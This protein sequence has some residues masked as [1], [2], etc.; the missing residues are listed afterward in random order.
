VGEETYNQFLFDS[1]QIILIKLVNKISV[2][3]FLIFF[4]EMKTNA[5]IQFVQKNGQII[6]VNIKKKIQNGI[7]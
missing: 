3:Q 2:L 1:Y 5:F 6:D 4:S 7:Q